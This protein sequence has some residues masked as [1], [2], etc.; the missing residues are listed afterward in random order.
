MVGTHAEIGPAS[1][2]APPV[3]APPV[4]APASHAEHGD[5]PPVFAFPPVFDAPPAPVPPPA[6]DPPFPGVPP[7]FPV[8]ALGWPPLPTRPPAPPPGAQPSQPLSVPFSSDAHPVPSKKIVTRAFAPLVVLIMKIP[9]FTQYGGRSAHV[10]TR[11]RIDPGHFP[12]RR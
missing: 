5:T 9:S 12:I 4:P 11:R 1:P 6:D 2:A 3:P 8:P 10:S 7:G